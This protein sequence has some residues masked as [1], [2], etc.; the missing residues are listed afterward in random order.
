[1]LRLCVFSMFKAAERRLLANNLHLSR[2]ANAPFSILERLMFHN[3][4]TFD[5]GGLSIVATRTQ[6]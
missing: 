2:V 3:A 1:M 6:P 4:F 5:D